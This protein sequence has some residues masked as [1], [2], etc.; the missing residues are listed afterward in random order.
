MAHGY[1][2]ELHQHH[3]HDEDH[4]PGEQEF[5]EHQADHHHD[6]EGYA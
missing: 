3:R 1:L 5:V 4:H 6:D 2:V